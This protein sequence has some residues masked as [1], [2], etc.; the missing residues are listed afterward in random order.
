MHIK[1]RLLQSDPTAQFD[2]DSRVYIYNPDILLSVTIKVKVKVA[3]SCLT[4]CDPM[5]YTVHEIL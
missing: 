3:Q 2:W 4:F 5:D 1:L